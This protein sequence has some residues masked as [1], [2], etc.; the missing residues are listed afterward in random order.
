MRNEVH[1]KIGLDGVEFDAKGD[2][3]FIERERNA[4]EAKLLPLGVD[5]VA[6]TRGTALPIQYV[7]ANEQPVQLLTGEKGVE[8][9]PFTPDH[10]NSK[11]Y[12]RTNLASFLKKY[13]LL[14]EQDFALFSAYFDELKNETKYFTKDDLERYY[15]EA[16][17][18]KPSNISMSLN[19][20]AE[21]GLIMDASDVEQKIPKP[22]RV[23][24]DGI[25]YV[26]AYKPK[27]E[28]EKKAT[29]TRKTRVKTK[30]EYAIINCDDLNLN[31]YPEVKSLKDF[32][33]K[34][35]MVLYII[36]N[37]DKGEWFTTGDVLCL[38]TDI[39][40]ETATKKQVDGVFGRE[41]RWFKLENVDGNKK[42]VHR[43]LL[44]EGKTFAQSLRSAE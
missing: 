2:S 36:T 24:S 21:K 32:K 19:R 4:F 29:K 41:K 12:S 43:R 25:A 34:M 35:M 26:D 27:E 15:D 38:L 10:G 42:L 18:A 7:E 39:F 37:E 22:Y 5:A 31:K 8:N 44:N 16:R 3:D 11:D 1:F 23:S 28:K 14:S 13:G 30:S 9:E 33:E 40:G 17:R 20:L 6:R